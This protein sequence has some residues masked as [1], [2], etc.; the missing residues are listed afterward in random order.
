MLKAASKKFAT[1]VASCAIAFGC[2]RSPAN[3]GDAAPSETRQI[4]QRLTQLSKKLAPL[5]L[6]YDDDVRSSIDGMSRSLL[7]EMLPA[8]GYLDVNVNRASPLRCTV[9]D[10]YGRVSECARSFV[11]FIRAYRAAVKA[12]KTESSGPPEWS[13]S[14]EAITVAFDSHLY[15]LKFRRADLKLVAAHYRGV[16]E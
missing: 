12:K 15:E 16:E 11:N 5:G 13:Q 10:L 7:E 8:D 9:A 1:V 2:S 3:A 6:Y 14:G 4:E